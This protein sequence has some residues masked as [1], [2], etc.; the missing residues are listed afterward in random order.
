MTKISRSPISWPLLSLLAGGA[1]AL[2]VALPP[3]ARAVDSATPSTSTQPVPADKGA[4][5]ATKKKKKSTKEE[6]KSE[7]Q[8]ID[9]YKAAHAMIYQQ[10]DYAAGIDKLKSLGHDDNADVA[11]LIG[12]S[13]RKLGRYED[14]KIWYERALVPDLGIL[15]AA[16]LAAGIAD[17]VGDIRVVIV[18]ERFELV[19]AGR[20][21]VLLVDHRVRGLVAVDELLLGFLLLL[22]GFFLLLGGLGGALVGRCRLRRGGGRGAIDGARLRW[23][24]NGQRQCAAGEQ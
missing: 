8:F 24:R 17:Q 23:Q 21:V 18:A 5:K 12:Y 15:V 10:H 22:G 4:T 13:S 9:G 6:K 16:E 7:Q 3:Q 11:N 1:L 20:V 19:D 2:T 14:S